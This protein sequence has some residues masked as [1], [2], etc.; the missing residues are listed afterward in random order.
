MSENKLNKIQK[1]LLDLLVKNHDESLTIREMQHSLGASSTSVIFRHLNNLEKKGFLKRNPNNPRDYLVFAQEPE[2]KIA[3]LNLYGLAQ[4]GYNGML[5][6]SRPID[7]IPIATKLLSFP[8]SKAFLVKAKGDSMSPR[9][10]DGDLVIAKITSDVPNGSIIICVNNEE[11]L[12]KNI[13]KDN[14]SII[15][16][17]L[18]PS[19]APF[20]AADDFRI[21]G[22]VKGIISKEG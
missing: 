17:S 15:L 10:I 4:C 3:W 8:S 14:N 19:Y 1:K 16:L 11:T 7:K 12:I 18:N 20:L 5:L 9:I 13:Q 22:E 21:V 6:D 2:K